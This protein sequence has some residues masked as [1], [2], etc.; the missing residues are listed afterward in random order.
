ML[1]HWKLAIVAASLLVGGTALADRGGDGKR[2]DGSDRR[3]KRMAK[4][5]TNSDGKLDQAER[6]AMAKAKFARLDKNND[7][8]LSLEE[9]QPLLERS[10]G[11]R[12][13]RRGG[14]RRMNK[15]E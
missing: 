8:V 15:D 1:E 3:A 5:D 2:G 12:G 7:G 6:A 11:K 4:F 10:H 14:D 13:D 9:A